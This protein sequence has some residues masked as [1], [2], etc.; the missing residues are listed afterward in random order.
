VVEPYPILKN[1]GVKVSWDDEIPNMNGKIKFIFQSPPTSNDVYYHGFY[2]GFYH[3]FYHIYDTIHDKYMFLSKPSITIHDHP[4]FFLVEK[5]TSR[6][7]CAS[8]H[9]PLS[10]NIPNVPQLKTCGDFLVTFGSSFS[11]PS[12]RVQKAQNQKKWP[13]WDFASGWE[14]NRIHMGYYWDINGIQMAGWWYTYPSQK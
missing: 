6:C 12:H 14:S 7:H 4:W 9:H 3:R 8:L 1:D 2:H 5:N 11:E 10:G 13:H